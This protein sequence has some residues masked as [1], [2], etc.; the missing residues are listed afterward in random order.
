[1][2][3]KFAI[4]AFAILS[5]SQGA[6]AYDIET[7]LPEDRNV[8]LIDSP[9]EEELIRGTLEPVDIAFELGDGYYDVRRCQL[10]RVFAGL[11]GRTSTIIGFIDECFLDYTE[12]PEVVT[13]IQRF[14]FLGSRVGEVEETNRVPRE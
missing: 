11:P 1:M 3:T 2:N 7:A 4:L 5:A 9:S 13:A 10:H 12:D 6:L 8:R 14:D